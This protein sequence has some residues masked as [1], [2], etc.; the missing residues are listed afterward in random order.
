MPRF[1]RP[2]GD[3][4]AA[5]RRGKHVIRFPRP[6]GD[7]PG[8]TKGRRTRRTVSPP[9]R[10]WTVPACSL[11]SRRRGFPAHA[12]MDPSTSCSALVASRFPRPRGDG[13]DTGG[14]DAAGG[15]VSPPT[16]GWTRRERRAPQTG[17]GFP[18]HAGM[19]PRARG[20]R[21]PGRRFPRPRGDGPAAV[22]YADAMVK[23][24]PPTRGW[25]LYSRRRTA[26]D[27]GFPAHAGMDRD[28]RSPP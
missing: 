25:T 24:S 7:G 21:P 15:K 13:P 22:D 20:R 8:G 3:G 16:R 28:R 6:R 27:G 1:P 11:R 9:T 26:G 23:V 5:N 17:L 14:V 10:G 12:G 19:D 18:A 4:P 2:R